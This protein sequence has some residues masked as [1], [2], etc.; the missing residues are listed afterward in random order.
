MGEAVKLLVMT[1]DR[2][3]P[4]MAGSALRAWE[5]SSV[6]ADAGHEVRL[7]AATGSTLPE[8]G[9]VALSARPPWRWADAVVAPP[10]ILPPRAFVGRRLLIVDGT[11]PLLAELAAMDQLPA[12]R[13]R[14]R[15]A[16]ARVPLVLA[17]ADAVL[18]A[19]EAQELW[20]RSR[21]DAA[22]RPGVPVLQVPFG[23]P[24]DDPPDE[25]ARIP[26]VPA[27]WRVVLWWGGVWPWLD[28]DTLLAARA[29]LEGSQISVV[30]PVAPRPDGAAPG[31]TSA[32]LLERAA[33]HGLEPPQVVPLERWIPYAH[34]HRVLHRASLIAVLHHPGD[35]ADLSFRTRALDGV[36]AGVPLL[37]TEGGAVAAIARS[38][39]WGAVVPAHR[40]KV[41]AA[42]IDLV[43]GEAEQQRCRLALRAARD[44]WR[45]NRVAEP[46]LAAL[47]GLPAV[48]RRSRIGAAWRALWAVRP[49]GRV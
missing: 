15:T 18:A 22:G 3:G 44:A 14:R 41:T 30:V 47:P 39:G 40:P 20:W 42:A 35:E 48:G 37:L 23:I 8:A 45:W 29:R 5:L 32:E 33:L 31:L 2:V 43:L 1:D 21:L 9:S 6:L 4:A 49:G 34:R 28:L 27:R 12:V 38:R 25:A 7:Y 19:G 11:T 26:G 10:W 36:W 46:L 13:R 16:A 17:R 24:R